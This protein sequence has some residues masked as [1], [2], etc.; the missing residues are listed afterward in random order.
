[1][2][3][4]VVLKKP[5]LGLLIIRIV[6]GACFIVHGILKFM[7]GTPALEQVGKS[8][9][10]FGINDFHLI[11]GVIA[12]TFE[13]VGGILVLLGAQFR[14]GVLLILFVL[15]MAFSTTFLTTPTFM[16]YAWP[17]ELFAVFFG[18]LFIGPG[19]YSVDKG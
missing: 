6:L 2:N 4:P 8:L 19:A 17:L 9:T 12:A 3:T 15:L 16:Q 7:G 18:L 5:D 10:F 1:M 11:F 14:V 13:I